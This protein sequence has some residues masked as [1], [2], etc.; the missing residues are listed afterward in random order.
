[1]VVAK[2]TTTE[3]EKEGVEQTEKGMARV[4]IFA[5]QKRRPG[6]YNLDGQILF[7]K[8]KKYEYVEVRTK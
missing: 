3:G 1:M 7:R 2:F 6:R 4:I 5:P 8:K